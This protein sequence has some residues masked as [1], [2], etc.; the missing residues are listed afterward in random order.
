MT[1]P[2]P[3]E[4][5]EPPEGWSSNPPPPPGGADWGAPPPPPPGGAGWGP[6]PS[7]GQWQ[8]PPPGATGPSGPRA[9]FGTRLL[10]AL[11]D[12]AILFVVNF[13]LRVVTGA[14]IGGILDFVVDAAYVIYLVQSP[15]GQTVG[16]RV[17]SIRT[18]DAV[19][20]GRVDAGKSVVRYVVG[21]VSG[22]ACL[23]GYFWMLWDPEK[24]TWHDKASG[25]YVVPTAYYPVERWPG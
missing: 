14:T 11:I 19:T 23:V 4:P 16:M 3:P 12:G 6:P 8:G 13:V 5:P 15:S 20:G 21:I 22:L 25:T 24:Q 10:G 2:P 7:P 9:D 18:I 1:Q 17:M